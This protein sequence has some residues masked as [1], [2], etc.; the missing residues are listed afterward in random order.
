[1]EKEVEMEESL[2]EFEKKRVEIRKKEGS[3][4][5]N[6]K[7]RKETYEQVKRLSRILDIKKYKVIDLSIM[8]LSIL[9]SE[10]I[11]MNQE[12]VPDELKTLQIPIEAGFIDTKEELFD[13]LKKALFK[14]YEAG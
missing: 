14:A 8:I 10:K 3:S 7:V 5:R 4:W 13:L 6:L 2:V 12:D 1:M 11:T 9:L